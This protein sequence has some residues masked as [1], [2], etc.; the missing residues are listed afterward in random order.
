MPSHERER[1]QVGRKPE[2]ASYEFADAA[3]IIDEALVCHVGVVRD[4]APVVIPMIHAREGK[5]LYLHASP[6]AGLANDGRAG[7]EVCVTV[8]LV[9]GLVLAR[10]GRSH[11]L[12]YRSVVAFGRVERVTDDGEKR[13]ALEAFVEH[14]APGRWSHLR[15]MTARE[16]REVDVLALD[17][18]EFSAKVRTGPPLD[19]DADRALPIWAGI[20]PLGLVPIGPPV[21]DAF[22]PDGV[23]TP[24]HVAA[25]RSD[26]AAG[27]VARPS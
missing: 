13:R 9:D 14:A 11:S 2:R 12:N 19:S 21:P 4:G 15:A 27:F 17:L 7:A 10:C 18:D 23:E 20:V 6:A 8:T 3:A 26:Q 5:R 25:W 1:K 16:V 24:D 22:V